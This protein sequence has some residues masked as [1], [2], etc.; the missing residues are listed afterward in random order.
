MALHSPGRIR[1][2]D[3]TSNNFKNSFSYSSFCTCK[4]LRRYPSIRPDFCNLQSQCCRKFINFRI[5]P[6]KNLKP[7]I[8]PIIILSGISIASGLYNI[9]DTNL[10][11]FFSNDY[12]IGIY[13]AAH[14]ITRIIT[15]ILVAVYSVIVPRLSYYST[16]GK[17]TDE[18]TTM[19]SKGINLIEIIC[20]QST[21]GSIVLSAPIITIMYGE[22]YLPSIQVMQVL[23]LTVFFVLSGGV[24][25]DTVF[26]PLRKDR[27]NLYPVLAGMITN[28]LF[29]CILIPK[30]GACGA[31]L[32]TV[33]AEFFVSATKLFL[34]RKFIS[35]LKIYS[36]LWKYILSSLIMGIVIWFITNIFSN[37]ILKLIS[38]FVSGITVYY[39]MLLILKS[40]FIKYINTT[41]MKSIK[42]IIFKIKNNGVTE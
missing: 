30:F 16:N 33:I 17:I 42:K 27:Y 21:I 22:N 1:I 31:A 35:G 36:E 15:S 26:T 11:G 24:L 13:A 10:L 23:S 32:G 38:G 28:I 4:R 8:K 9:I 39:I 41:I 29:S 34:A 6:V 19:L 12:Q 20:I 14:K 3:N 2:Y 40:S 5:V 18:Y 7:H 25:G 37:N